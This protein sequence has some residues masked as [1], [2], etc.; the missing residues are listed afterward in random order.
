MAPETM[1]TK[2]RTP[3]ATSVTARRLATQPGRCGKGLR[4]ARAKPSMISQIKTAMAKGARMRA[5][6][7][8]TRPMAH[9]AMSQTPELSHR[10]L[11]DVSG[12][13]MTADLLRLALRAKQLHDRSLEPLFG[14]LRAS[15]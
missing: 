4:I 2:V 5:P 13:S 15:A 7:Q 9:V 8:R 14:R 6:L 1:L 12:V 3:R 11:L 10:A